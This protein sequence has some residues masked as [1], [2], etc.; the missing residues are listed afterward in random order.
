MLKTFRRCALT[1]IPTHLQVPDQ[2]LRRPP[3]P[4]IC[5]KHKPRGSHPIQQVCLPPGFKLRYGMPLLGRQRSKTRKYV[6]STSS[7]LILILPSCHATSRNYLTC[8]ARSLGA[9]HT[10]ILTVLLD[11]PHT[12]CVL[13]SLM[14][15]WMTSLMTSLSAPGVP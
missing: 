10:T 3:T 5:K 7:I 14:A 9:F 12:S 2:N 1:K 4:P 11:A 8:C 15:S 6:M 13:T